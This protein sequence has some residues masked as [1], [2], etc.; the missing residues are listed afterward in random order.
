MDSK[1][2]FY[3]DGW[4]GSLPVLELPADFSRINH[5]R[6]PQLTPAVTLQPELVQRLQRLSNAVNTTMPMTVLT[7]FLIFLHRYSKAADLPVGVHATA[8][9]NDERATRDFVL[10]LRT[11]IENYENF[12]SM[13][14]HVH[15]TINNIQGYDVDQIVSDLPSIY[16]KYRSAFFTACFLMDKPGLKPLQVLEQHATVELALVFAQVGEDLQIRFAYDGGLFAEEMIG[17][18]LA[19]FQTLLASIATSPE[20]SFLKLPLI[21]DAEQE[22]LN[23]FNKNDAP[24]P[25]EHTIHQLFEEQVKLRPHAIAVRYKG[26]ELTYAELDARVNQFAHYLR[27]KGYRRDTF[28]GLVLDR[29]IEMIISILAVLKSGGAYLPIDP[30]APQQRIDYLLDDSRT[31]V[32]ITRE[33]LKNRLDNYPFEVIALDNEWDAI[34]QFETTAPKNLNTPADLAYIIYTSGSSGKPKGTM[35][36][37]HGVCNMAIAQGDCFGVNENS[38]VLQF[39]SFSFDASV[40]EIFFAVLRGAALILAPSEEI[41]DPLALT[42]LLA[43]ERITFICSSPALIAQL[44]PGAGPQLETMVTAGDACSTALAEQWA[45]RVNFTNSYGPTETTVCAT[46][47][48]STEAG[49]VVPNPLPIGRPLPNT[50]IY[51]LNTELQEQPIGVPGE[52]FIEDPGIARGYLHRPDLTREKF[53]DHPFTPG[54]KLYR[55]GDLGRYR[56]DGNIEFLGRIDNQ[57][58]IRGHRIEIGEIE[59]VLSQHKEI[60]ENVVVVKTDP[61]GIKRLVAYIVTNSPLRSDEVKKYLS[62]S[63]SDYMIPSHIIRLSALPVN[64]NGKVD[65][66]ALPE[67]EDVLTSQNEYVAPQNDVQSLIVDIWQEV[68]GIKQVGIHDDF[69][70]IG[71]HSLNIL[72]AVI[73]LKPHYPA[74][75]IQDFYKYRTVA[76][77]EKFFEKAVNAAPNTSDVEEIEELE[78]H[79]S[80]VGQATK[81]KP[82]RVKAPAKAAQEIV[83]VKPTAVFLTGATGYLGAHILQDLLTDTEATVYCLVRPSSSMA[84]YERLLDTMSFYFGADVEQRMEQRVVAVVGDLSEENLGLSQED[85]TMLNT[86]VD[87]IIHCGADVRHYGEEDHF[88][89]V[90]VRGTQYLID[91]AR[92]REGVRFHFVSTLSNVMG[93]APNDPKLYIPTEDDFDRGQTLDSPYAESKFR[94]EALVRQA[95]EEGVAASVYRAG[96]LCGHS[97]TGQFQR[98]ID[99]NAFYRFVKAT[100]MLEV[101]AEG[102]NYVDLTPVNYASKVLVHFACRKESVGHTFHLCNAKQITGDDFIHLLQSFGY[103][104]LM[105]SGEQYGQWLFDENTAKEHYEAVQLILAALM[106]ENPHGTKILFDCSKTQQMLAG[107]GVV[108]PAPDRRLLFNILKYGIE[109]GYFPTPKN[110]HLIANS[111]NQA[112]GQTSEKTVLV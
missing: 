58:K 109:I 45:K 96:N 59:H 92:A 49:G 69:F 76:D 63:L 101:T 40:F 39:A 32:V 14:T 55:S 74:L 43:R 91:M 67:P 36:A 95:I 51:I 106:E 70:D 47:W 19:N 102:G 2:D 61:N 94:A 90:N 89:K 12:L 23:S 105:M 78:D 99:S 30:D 4:Q 50:K 108:S 24:F 42:D 48:S 53:I 31:S 8:L 62:E 57:V 93:F 35:L 37:H 21:N 18:M 71:G 11:N 84:P 80:R 68:L 77:M 82:R 110:W 60:R 9:Y 104:I 1:Q 46:W 73:R 3:W 13:F 103:S 100:L 56:P 112:P 44:P 107:S 66:R 29:S 79:L 5:Q 87:T 86:T 81:I 28:I 65:T 41:R 52:I 75:T 16:N 6:Q 34:D 64:I 20:T 25:M 88:D 17:R 15:G 26:Q 7:S 85:Q 22:L 38:R 98:N 10:P 83:L 97:E 27:N 33:H 111:V 54:L 72:P